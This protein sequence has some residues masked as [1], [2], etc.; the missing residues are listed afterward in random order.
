MVE[1]RVIESVF[2]GGNRT[3]VPRVNGLI[4]GGSREGIPHIYHFTGVPK[5]GIV[6]RYSEQT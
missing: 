4:E 5:D 3:S 2:E 6:L 1:R